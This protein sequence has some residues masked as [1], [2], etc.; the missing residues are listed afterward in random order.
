MR[1]KLT[2]QKPKRS[3]QKIILW[4]FVIVIIFGFFTLLLVDFLT[5]KN[6]YNKVVTPDNLDEMIYALNDYEIAP[7]GSYE[8]EMST[9][10]NFPS[11]KMASP[12]AYIGNSLYNR[13]PVYFTIVLKE[14]NEELYQSPILPI[15][16]SLEKIKL[17]ADF[18]KGNYN[19]IL[20][21]HLLD[22]ELSEISTVSVTM[23]II[24]R[25]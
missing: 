19:C 5:E 18:E 10:W 13:N 2:S 16:S 8:I 23:T 15:G 7:E 21:Y 3:T 6:S 17:D 11:S 14:T 12:D 25:N 22:T 9:L 20:I 4:I 1:N 24:I